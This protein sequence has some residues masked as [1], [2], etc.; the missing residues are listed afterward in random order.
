M[1]QTEKVILNSM[2]NKFRLFEAA[3]KCGMTQESCGTTLR[4]MV[5]KGYLK[6]VSWGVYQKVIEGVK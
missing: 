6:K 4:R 2:G 5:T 3:L 1:N